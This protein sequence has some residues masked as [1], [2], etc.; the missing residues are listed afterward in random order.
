MAYKTHG[1]TAETAKNLL[2]DAGAVYLNYGEVDERLLGA[3]SGGNTFSVER[4]VKEIEVDGARGKVK[5][6]RRIISENA[7]LSVNLLE[8]SA[9]N[10]QLALGAA[11]IEDVMDEGGIEKIADAVKPRGQIQDS[12]YFKNIA[13]VCTVSGTTQPCVIILHNV[14]ADDNLEI[15]F[16]DKE[17]GKP[18]VILSAHY[19]PEQLEVVPYEIRYPVVA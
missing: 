10:F 11:D 6:F 13:L 19:D 8:A 4:E 2:L 3:T 16:E 7:S 14:L 17:E 1:I 15:S 12:D 5:G 18:E 9:K